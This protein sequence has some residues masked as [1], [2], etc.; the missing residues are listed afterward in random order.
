MV[1]SNIFLKMFTPNYILG[2]FKKWGYS[3][4]MSVYQRVGIYFL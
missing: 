3:I 2:D 4:A 1:V